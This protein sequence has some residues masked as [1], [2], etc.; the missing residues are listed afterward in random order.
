MIGFTRAPSTLYSNLLRRNANAQMQTQLAKAE[1]EL[2]TGVK[3]DIYKSLG[4]SASEALNLNASL[5][6]DEAQ[7]AANTLLAGRIDTMS[8][9]LGSMRTAVQQTQE[10]AVANSNV[11]SGTSGGIQT[12][13]QT[14]LDAL[15]SLVNTTYGGVPLFAGPADGTTAVQDYGSARADTGLTPQTVIEDVLAGGLAT[16]ADASARIAELD[17]IFSN[18]AADPDENYDALFF[19]GATAA[20]PMSVGIGDGITI[21]YGV[22]ANDEAFRQVFQGL[23]ML[24]STDVSEIQDAEAYTTWVGAAMD[25]LSSGLE[26]LLDSQIQLDSASAR[27]DDANARMEDR[28]TLYKGRVAEMVEVDSY[29]AA[30]TITAMETQLQASYAATARLSQLSFLNYMS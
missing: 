22:Q 29:E 2:A 28:A 6:R 8:G 20:A 24:A 4:P 1:Q 27:I 15:L 9:A 26:G 16:A 21:T 5:E 3:S 7:I 10:L 13:A 25:R 11:N 30:T 17:A 12:Q 19:T 18:A 23:A 14:S